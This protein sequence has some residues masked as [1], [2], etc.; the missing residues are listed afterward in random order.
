[1]ETKM[2]AGNLDKT[3]QFPAGLEEMYYHVRLSNP[4]TDNLGN[5][6]ENDKIVIFTPDEFAQNVERSFYGYQAT[7][8]HDPNKPDSK[9][10]E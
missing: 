9:K 4:Q 8:L 3:Y 6:L 5:K 2:R 7:V 10:N 1:M